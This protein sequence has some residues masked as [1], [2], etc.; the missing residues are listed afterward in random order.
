M[1]RMLDTG[2][3]A[4]DGAPGANPAVVLSHHYWVRRFARDP[5]VLG[6]KILVN[7]YPMNVVGVSATNQ[8]D[9][10]WSGSNSGAGAFIGAPGVG[11]LAD[12]GAVANGHCAMWM[13]VASYSLR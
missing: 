5:N 8:S 13:S 12:S 9:G 6:R 4:D 1:T 11:V 7:D 10:L 3:P 2:A